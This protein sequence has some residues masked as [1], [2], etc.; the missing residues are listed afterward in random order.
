MVSKKCKLRKEVRMISR[1]K[2]KSDA[3]KQLKGKWALAIIVCL[4]YTLI[5]EGS[6]ASTGSSFSESIN[7]LIVTLNI[8]GIL[9]YGPIEAGLARFT[10][11]L[12]KDKE[13]AKFSN[14]FSQFK[15]FFKLLIMSAIFYISVFI[16]LVL[17]IIPGI[18]LALMFSQAYFIAV[19]NPELSAI[20][21]LSKST[22]MMKGHKRDLFVLTL[23]FIGWLLVCIITLGIGF[24]WYV[25]Y[26]QMTLTNFYLELN[27]KEVLDI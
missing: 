20:K 17:F 11:N 14:L 6:T 10:L 9:L 18:I 15:L 27:K 21:C 3:K 23:S 4:I 12:A 8:I 5:I 16:G 22:S 7:G 1:Q 25:P 13:N 2:L 26:Y 24:L 19:E